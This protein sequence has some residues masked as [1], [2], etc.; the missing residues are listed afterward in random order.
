[1]KVMEGGGESDEGGWG[2]GRRRGSIE[3]LTL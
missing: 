2:A 1:M 3:G